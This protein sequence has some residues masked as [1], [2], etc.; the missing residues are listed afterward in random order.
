MA[1]TSFPKGIFYDIQRS[2]PMWSDYTCFTEVIK[3]KKY[4]KRPTITK[5]FKKLVD[6]DD[7]AKADESEIMGFLF[8]IAR[9]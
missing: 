7:Y 2:N 8:G 9:G 3:D 6:P 1:Q 4:L 5:W